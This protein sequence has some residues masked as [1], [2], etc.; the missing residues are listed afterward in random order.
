MTL[1]QPIPTPARR[2]GW[3][4]LG[5]FL[6]LL[7]LVA[8]VL[9]WTWDWNW[10]R[11]LVEA[12][13]SAALGREVT[14][15][16]LEV[17]PGRVTGVTAYGV[18]V[19]NPAGFEG[20]DFVTIAR[21]GL[22]FEPLAWWRSG[23]LVLRTIDADQPTINIEQTGAGQGNWIAPGTSS[24]A[25][26]VGALAIQNGAAHV[27][28]V[29]EKSDVTMRIAT[30]HTANGD[31]LIIDGK[32]THARQ[33][34]TFHVVGGALLAL[35]D[36]ATPYPI[37]LELANG[38][39]RITLKGH[40]R[41]PLALAGADLNLVLTGPDMAL[42]LP[43]TGIATPRTPSYR[44]SGR[45]DFQNGKVKFTDIAGR[46]GSSDLSGELDVDPRDGHPILSGTLISHRV[47]LADLGGFV[48]STPGRASTRSRSC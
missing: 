40:I 18:K 48:G 8:G 25:L 19:A 44:V 43:L 5:G 24:A 13:V 38:E 23:R 15:E 17:S 47:D 31:V 3:R 33:P 4:Y 46:V 16:R 27:H 22:T 28:V 36:A 11:P 37:D 9:V 42:L 10:F 34:I 41:D 32:G 30:S 35:R 21:L 1:E 20:P 29:R 2:S 45:L 7:V 14:V 6:V 12:Q 26:E 39:T